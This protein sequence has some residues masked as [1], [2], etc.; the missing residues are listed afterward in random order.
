M[1][2]E[3]VQE[4]DRELEAVVN[5]VFSLKPADLIEELGLKTPTGWSYS[6]TAA[7]GHFG[8]DIFP[9]EKTNKVDALKAAAG[10]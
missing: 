8:R 10:I 2:L 5:K 9:W 6:Q 7:Y 4:T 3:R 1:R